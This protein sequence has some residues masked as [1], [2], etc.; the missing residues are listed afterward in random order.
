MAP[1]ARQVAQARAREGP[2]TPTAR[3]EAISDPTK[4]QRKLVP[5]FSRTLLARTQMHVP[6][7]TLRR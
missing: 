3:P 1:D 6:W 7:E 2:G 4:E 5:E